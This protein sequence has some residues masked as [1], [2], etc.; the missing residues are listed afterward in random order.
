MTR[1]AGQFTRILK[2]DSFVVTRHFQDI[3]LYQEH[4]H[5]Q[6]ILIKS[7]AYPTLEARSGATGY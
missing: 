3:K 6:T 5:F 1:K 4:E 7:G 2:L